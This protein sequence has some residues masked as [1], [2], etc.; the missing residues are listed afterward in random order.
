MLHGKFY[1]AN[2]SDGV[3]IM[4]YNIMVSN[5]AGALPHRA[6]LIREANKTLSWLSTYFAPGG[7]Q[8]TGDAEEKIVCAVK[9]RGIKSKGGDGEHLQEYGLSRDA[10]CRIMEGLGMN[11]P[12]TDV[13]AAKEAPKLQ[14]CPTY[15]HKGDSAWNKS[16]GAERW[17][18]LYV[19]GAQHDS[20]RIVNKSIADGAKGVLVLTG[21]GSGRLQRMMEDLLGIVLD[22]ADLFVDNI[23]IESGTQDMSQDEL[24]KA[25]EK[26]LR[27][28]LDVVHRH[29][30]VCKPTNAS[31]FVKEVEFAGH[32]VRHG[33]RR[34]MPGKLAAVNH[35]ERPTTISELRS[36]MGF[37]NY[38]LGYV[39]MYA[40]L[41]GPLHKMLQV[42]KFDGRKGGKKKLAW[43]TE[44]EEAFE[45]PKRTLLGKLG[46]FLMIP[47]KRICAPHRCIR[48]CRGSSPVDGL[49]GRFSCPSGLL[50]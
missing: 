29:Q 35:W 32:V 44:A 23:I 6:T 21:L 49:R 20:E 13:F 18:H 12:S 38:Y 37:C 16:W 2:L 42:G 46:L 34:P 45:T 27:R 41:S 24:I 36:F 8:C 47:A 22:C 25:Q 33:Q 3:M 31:L 40:E 4:G 14:R 7:S 48:L 5:S 50:E 19:H 26:D 30:M 39:R 15:W 9:A 10:F 28:V 43:T 1:E 17:G 11:T